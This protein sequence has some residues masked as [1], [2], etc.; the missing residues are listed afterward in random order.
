MKWTVEYRKH[1]TITK[2]CLH[3]SLFDT[4]FDICYSRTLYTGFNDLPA[5][6]Q[7]IIAIDMKN[8]SVIEFILFFGIPNFLSVVCCTG[9]ELVKRT[10]SRPVAVVFID[11]PKGHKS[12]VNRQKK[13]ANVHWLRDIDL[14]RMINDHPRLLRL[15]VTHF[16]ILRI[17]FTWQA[18]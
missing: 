2:G 10:S 17:L 3:A 4:A 8:L 18:V 14:N 7:H 5:V 12:Q 15:R 6:A 11:S 1:E 16:E 9:I 13:M